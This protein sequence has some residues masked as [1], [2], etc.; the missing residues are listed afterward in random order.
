MYYEK[1]KRVELHKKIDIIKKQT[2][3]SLFISL[4]QRFLQRRW[5]I[6]RN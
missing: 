3:K 5:M 1:T 4:L 6:N 2:N